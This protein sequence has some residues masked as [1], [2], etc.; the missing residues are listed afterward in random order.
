MR[1]LIILPTYN[2][3][4]NIEN[5][6]EKIISLPEGLDILIIDDN[7]QD[8]TIL[9]AE[10]LVKKY[11]ER[12]SFIRR[13][14][15]LGLGTA[16]IEGF[17]FA[18]NHNYDY[19]FEMDADLSHDPCEIK[20]FLDAIKNFD[21]V[22]GSRYIDGIRIMNWPLDRL[23]LSCAANIYTRLMT[24]IDLT[25]FTGGY[26][27]FR[28]EALSALPLD[29]I[30]T[31]GYGFQIEV[32]FLC[33]RLGLKIKEIPIVF[34]ER[35]YGSSKMSQAIVREAFFLGIKLFFRRFLIK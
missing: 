23:I 13:S 22:I 24:G 17:K 32:N 21:V 4:S 33:H 25:D 14:A 8:G 31:N 1:T 11:G 7:S 9:L 5:V 28:R 15:K 29:A 27:C 12:L 34:A 26:K 30:R 6:V 35:K 18:L 19:I 16:Y 10:G 3:A 20:N 2:E